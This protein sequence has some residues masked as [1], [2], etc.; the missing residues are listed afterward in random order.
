MTFYHKFTLKS[1]SSIFEDKKNINEILTKY[2]IFINL[3]D[4]FLSFIQHEFFSMIK[5]Y[6]VYFINIYK[7]KFLGP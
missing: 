5:R 1:I 4:K 2:I 3:C 7:Q 6:S